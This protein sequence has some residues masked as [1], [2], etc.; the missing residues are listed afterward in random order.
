MSLGNMQRDRTVLTE[1]FGDHPMLRILEFLIENKMFDYSK[2][3]MAEETNL[4]KVTFLKYFKK[5][6]GLGLVVVTRRF[7][8]ASLYTL[9]EAN[10]FTKKF[11]GLVL[12]LANQNAIL[13]KDKLGSK[14][15]LMT[16]S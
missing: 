4:S 12:L 9:N 5:L 1:Y 16:V 3:Q 8:K 2:K 13:I 6:E 10:P 14:S 7:G 11:I 15:H